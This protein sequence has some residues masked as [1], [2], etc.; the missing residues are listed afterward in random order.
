MRVAVV[1][2][3]VGGLA[4][5]VRLAAAGHDVTVLEAGDAPGGKCG[6]VG[7]RPLRVGLRARRC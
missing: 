7:P 2:A 1:G 3:G 6:R 4:T 5:A